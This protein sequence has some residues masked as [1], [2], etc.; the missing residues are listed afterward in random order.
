VVVLLLGQSH[1]EECERRVTEIAN[2]DPWVG[3]VKEGFLKEVTL[4]QAL[5]TGLEL[6]TR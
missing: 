4:S 3:T 5:K 1:K 6:M 2:Q